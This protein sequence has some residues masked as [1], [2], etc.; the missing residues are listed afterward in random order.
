MTVRRE[1][2]SRVIL[3]L[4][5]VVF[6][7]TPV[8]SYYHPSHDLRIQEHFELRAMTAESGLDASVQPLYKVKQSSSELFTLCDIRLDVKRAVSGAYSTETV[9]RP[10]EIIRIAHYFRAPPSLPS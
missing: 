4:S 5:A 8:S 1:L 3:L 10:H 2:G 7:I 6:C 9:F